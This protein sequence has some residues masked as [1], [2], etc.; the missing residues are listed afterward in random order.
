[1]NEGIQPQPCGCGSIDCGGQKCKSPHSLDP[2]L[3]TDQ[4][5]AT[6]PH[7]LH[8][9]VKPPLVYLAVPYSHPDPAVR[10]QRFEAANRAAGKLMKEGHH[11]FSPISH[12]HPIA[13]ACDL[14]LGWDYWQAFDRAYLTH[15][16]KIVVLKIPG[17]QES[18]R[19]AGELAIAKELGL[20]IEYMEA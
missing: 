14:P 8:G 9:V 5:D 1:M 11:V 16:H 15:C 3:G 6:K 17:W 10:K 2:V 13:E 7:S 12:T 18:K 20:I 19:V 4:T